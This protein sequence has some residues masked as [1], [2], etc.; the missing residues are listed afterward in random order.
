MLEL[1]FL[2]LC[3]AH[4]LPRPLVNQRIG[5]WTPDFLWPE[6]RLIVET[7]GVEFHRTA[8]A[9]RRDA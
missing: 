3:D 9:K 4:G 2:R 5:D 1:R 8:A 7:D 6:W